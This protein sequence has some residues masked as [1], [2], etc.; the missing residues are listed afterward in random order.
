MQCCTGV[1][2]FARLAGRMNLAELLMAVF[3]D[4][5]FIKFFSLITPHFLRFAAP[6]VGAGRVR[7]QS[8]CVG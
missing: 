4:L 5:L 2:V 6:R 7:A 1:F 3:G 8:F